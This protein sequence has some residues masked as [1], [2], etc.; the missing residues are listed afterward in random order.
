MGSKENVL[1]VLG[2]GLESVFEPDDL[3]GPT[4]ISIEFGSVEI[5]YAKSLGVYIMMRHGPQHAIPPHLINYRANFAS[6]RKLGILSI[7]ATSSVGSLRPSIPVG[8]YVV[9]DQ[10]IDF[11]RNRPFSIYYDKPEDFS[12][13]DM[14]EPYSERVRHA[15][16]SSLKKNHVRSFRPRGT[17][18]CTEGPRFETPAEIRMFSRL[19]GDVVGMTGVPEVVIANELGLEYANLAVV[20]NMAAGLQ[21]GKMNPQKVVG[22]MEKRAKKTMS[23]LRDAI[24]VLKSS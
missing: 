24:R 21:K 8:C 22:Q 9:L 1:V 7:I 11:T 10:F 20:C 16:L 14:T 23:I 15:L 13:T 2:T 19:G 6:A 5:D 4:S 17:Y 12:H 18:V 3:S